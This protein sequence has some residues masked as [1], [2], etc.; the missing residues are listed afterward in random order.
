MLFKGNSSKLE[1]LIEKIQSNKENTTHDLREALGSEPGSTSS[2]RSDSSSSSTIEEAPV[3]GPS[4]VAATKAAVPAGRASS[5]SSSCSSSASSQPPDSELGFT[6]GV[7]EA[8]PYPCQ[9]CAKAFPRLNYLKKHEQSHAE[10]MP[11]R[12]EFCSRLFKHKRSRDRHVKLHTGDRK[13]RCNQCEAAFSRSDHLKI[14][15]KT[16]DTQKPFQCSACNRGYNTAAALTSHSQTHKR[17][18]SLP[19]SLPPRNSP[20]QSPP[21]APPRRVTPA[22]SPAAPAFPRNLTPTHHPHDL[23]RAAHPAAAAAAAV[24]FNRELQQVLQHEASSP[25]GSARS[26]L[27]AAAM[28]AAALAHSA[29]L[30]FPTPTLAC[31]YC[32]KDGFTSMEQLQLHVQAMHGS[33]LNGEREYQP[34]SP[35]HHLSSARQPPVSPS[36]PYTCDF[37]TMKF[38]HVQSL[39]KHTLAVHAMSPATAF[40]ADVAEQLKPTDLSIN[41]KSNGKSPARPNDTL[42]QSTYL[43]N[44]CNAHCPDFESFRSHQRTHLDAEHGKSSP[45]KAP[46]QPNHAAPPTPLF[47]C[48]ECSE[49]FPNENL[50]EVHCLGHFLTTTT[51]FS[52]QSCLKSFQRPDELQK[53]LMDSHSHQ[54]FRCA[55]CREIFDSRVAA[56]VHFAVKHSTESRVLRCVA[57]GENSA[58]FRSEIEFSLH[59]KIHHLSLMEKQQTPLRCLY[60]NEFFKSEAELQY[61]AA[62]F[63]QKLYRCKFCDD[64]FHV[65]FQLDKHLEHKHKEETGKK[66]P[67]KQ[68]LKSPVQVSLVCA[69]C[70]ESCKSRADL[71]A[72]MKT[73]HQTRPSTNGTNGVPLGRHKCNICDMVCV[74][75][76]L[77]AEH[78][79]ATHCKVLHGDTCSVCKASIGG[80]EHFLSHMQKH[81]PGSGSADIGLPTACIICRQTVTS[82]HE[83]QL[84]AK[85][86]LQQKQQQNNHPSAGGVYPKEQLECKECS[87]RFDSVNELESHF[88]KY[89]LRK[90]SFECISCQLSFHTEAEVR[91]HVEVAHAPDSGQRCRLCQESFDTPLRLQVHLIEHTFVGCPT[92]ACYLC[93]AVFTAATGLQ[94]H[95]NSHGASNKPYD[96][97]KCHL[98]FFFR[99]ELENHQFVHVGEEMMLDKKQLK[100]EEDDHRSEDE[101]NEAISLT[102]R[103][104]KGEIN[105]NEISNGGAIVDPG[106]AELELKKLKLEAPEETQAAS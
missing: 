44:Q 6:L 97:S 13:Y 82:E 78:K 30:Q 59:V 5:A 68:Q 85:F 55:L 63:H 19:A 29:G 39:H 80:E 92:F 34:P 54:L 93:G 67:P 101:Q 20:R 73:H 65:E 47:Q 36:Q 91:N 69:Y 74:T 76:A 88:S 56:Q 46:R 64:A 4:A 52:C 72:H 60:C 45:P 89:H 24:L 16:H 53:H 79:L 102:L 33:I 10:H 42:S 9:F 12:C 77:L 43:C 103:K 17:P 70:Q 57:C 41:G 31:I 66:S 51:E 2:W 27:N 25:P 26:A 58:K 84:H 1:L 7:T 90:N 11:F 99:A 18:P 8:T 32:T 87:G 35:G 22:P 94:R 49:G 62:N 86:H 61:H 3:E 75:P 100:E 95:M 81:C 48:P 15:M 21:S 14:H 38:D 104:R 50:L 71:E 23:L 40:G 37:C 98:R 105:G 28:A 83:V 106:A 96:C